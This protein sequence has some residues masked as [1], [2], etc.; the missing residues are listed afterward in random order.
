MIVD[1]KFSMHRKGYKTIECTVSNSMNFAPPNN[2]SYSREEERICLRFRSA[3]DEDEKTLVVR[4][5][6]KEAKAL[7]ERLVEYGNK[8]LDHEEGKVLT[9]PTPS[10]TVEK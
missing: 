10:A 9:T 4:M 6:R 1:E 8:I 5:S 2:Y 7:G 3:N